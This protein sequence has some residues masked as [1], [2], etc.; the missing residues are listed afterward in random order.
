MSFFAVY[1]MQQGMLVGLTLPLYTV[2]ASPEAWRPSVDTLASIGCLTG[3]AV[4]REGLLQVQSVTGVWWMCCMPTA[5]CP[6]S[7]MHST[8]GT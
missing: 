3:E 8:V 1:L 6:H 7:A 2:F 5:P 4:C